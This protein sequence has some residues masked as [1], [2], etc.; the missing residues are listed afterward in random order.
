MPDAKVSQRGGFRHSVASL[1]A[2]G[3]HGS[4][5]SL[6]VAFVANLFVAAAKLAAGLITGSAALLAEAAHSLA[7][8]TNEVMIGVS[9]RRAGRPADAEHPFGYGGLR[10][11]WAFLA[12][13]S[14]FLIGGCL[15]VG[16]AVND[17]VHGNVIGEFLVAWIVLGIA[18]LADGTAL[19]QTMRQ[20]RREAALWDLPTI[21]Y[22]RHTSDPTLRAL[23]V[24]D[25]AAL[26][27]LG[28]AAAGLLVH[29]LGGP[30]SSDAIASLLIG[31]LLGLT[32]IGLARPLADLLIGRSIL[33]ARLELARRTLAESPAVDEIRQLYAVHVAPQEVLLAAKVHPAADMDAD[34]LAEAMDEID[35]R[36]RD[37]LPE[38]GEVFIDVTAHGGRDRQ[39]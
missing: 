24:E 36:L 3:S 9:F 13:I 29:E 6:I 15:S 32:A 14:S 23:A 19:V 21:R 26:I 25:T 10:F 33:P 8:S 34:E 16:L 39:D 35:S 30:A 17:L 18:A 11:L 37:E 38:V 7:D 27:G 1:R 31:L 28:L 2:R 20:A 4:R 12:A 22:L 5:R